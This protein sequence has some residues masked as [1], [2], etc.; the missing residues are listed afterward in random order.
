MTNKEKFLINNVGFH[1]EDLSLIRQIEL[2]TVAKELGV[3]KEWVLLA[4]SKDSL[5]KWEQWGFNLFKKPEFKAEIDSLLK[6]LN[7]MDE[8]EFQKANS[9]KATQG[10]HTSYRNFMKCWNGVKAQG[11]IYTKDEAE[12]LGLTDYWV[13]GYAVKDSKKEEVK[14]WVNT[15]IAANEQPDEDM[16]A[17]FCLCVQHVVEAKI[18]NPIKQPIKELVKFDK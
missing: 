17:Y 2:K 11:G 8:Y 13:V 9:K 12:Q 15:I 4:L 14:N 5:E 18:K 7:K 6:T 1:S 16:W 10:I 3:P